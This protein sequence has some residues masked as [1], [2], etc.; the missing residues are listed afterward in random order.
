MSGL[1]RNVGLARRAQSLSASP[2][3]K[4]G[5]QEALRVVAF[6]DRAAASHLTWRHAELALGDP[7][8]NPERR[9][10][11]KFIPVI[12]LTVRPDGIR[13]DAARNV[14]QPSLEGGCIPIMTLA[15]SMAFPL[16]DARLARRT[17][18]LFGQLAVRT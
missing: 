14:H 10:L 5:A 12:W 9:L 3:T 8:L 17:H 6:D 11:V 18:K 2:A 15:D 4:V 1:R 13:N 7:H 16:A